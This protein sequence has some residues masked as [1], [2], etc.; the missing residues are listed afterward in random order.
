VSTSIDFRDGDIVTLKQF[1]K[2]NPAWTEASLRWLRFNQSSN[3]LQSAGA[4]IQQGR[5]VLLDKPRFFSWIR[6]GQRR[7]ER[8]AAKTD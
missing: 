5:R 3:G 1:S 4:F 6:N 2:E 7:P 8:S